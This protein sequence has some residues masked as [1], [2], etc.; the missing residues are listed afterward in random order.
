MS[1]TGNRTEAGLRLDS[2][3]SVRLPVECLDH[4]EASLLAVDEYFDFLNTELISSELEALRP[5]PRFNACH[6][7]AK[8]VALI[9]SIAKKLN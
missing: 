6:S 1:Q 2:A 9:S 8:I 5:T 7:I 4:C 3:V